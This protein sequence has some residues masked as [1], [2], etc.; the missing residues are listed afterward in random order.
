VT[1]RYGIYF[2][3]EA[4]ISEWQNRPLEEIY[5]VVFMDAVHYKVRSEG[6]W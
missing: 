3:F 1:I 2:T 4:L 6:R 5:G